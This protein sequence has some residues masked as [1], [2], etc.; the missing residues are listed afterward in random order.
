MIPGPSITVTVLD[1]PVAAPLTN[2][3]NDDIENESITF[4]AP[5][6]GVTYEFR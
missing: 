5:A 4:E 6:G 1:A 3:P 2:K